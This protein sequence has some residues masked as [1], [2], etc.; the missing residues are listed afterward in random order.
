[1]NF[2][3]HVPTR[4]L[5]GRGC[6]N[7][8][9]KMELP[10]KKALVLISSGKSMR[11]NGY[12]DRV[13]NVLKE[14][15]VESVVYAGVQ[16]N[17]VVS[18]V[19]EGCEIFI[20]EGCDFVVGLGG[21]STIDCAKSVAVMAMNTEYDIWDY[22][23]NTEKGDALYV[24]DTTRDSL[25][26]MMPHR[27]KTPYGWKSLKG[28]YPVVGIT[29]TAGTGSEADPW[30]V[31]TNPDT[32]DKMGM[33]GDCTFPQI[34]IV[35]PELM[36]SV[37]RDLT[38]YQG[39]DALFHCMENYFG[40]PST[41]LGH[42]FSIEGIREV[43]KYIERVVKDGNDI[44]AREGMAYANLMGAFSLSDGGTCAMHAMS[45]TIGAYAHGI[46]H[47]AAL[48]CLCEAYFSFYA[49]HRIEKLKDLG[50]FMGVDVDAME[51]DDQYMAPVYMLRKL[52]KACGV[53]SITLLDWRLDP[54]KIPEIA[55]K[56]KDSHMRL[57][58]KDPFMLEQDQIE[59]IIRSAC[60]L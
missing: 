26:I 23:G 7:D 59:A 21:G 31:T 55:Y 35:D 24:K 32:S 17:P 20:R 36:C 41:R 51:G 3:F 34:A 46:P 48:I 28:A 4:I 10:G 33:G 25:D 29:T 54:E 57:F 52:K 14:A 53:D 49:Q 50:R 58:N 11:V 40:K 18:N 47:G 38:I 13:L 6:L 16:A 22:V 60:G 45:E 56:A 12:L 5:F 30:C 15:G 39:F 8:L 19:R 9:A 37:P 44:E 42:N 43:C 27:I 1:M 2:D